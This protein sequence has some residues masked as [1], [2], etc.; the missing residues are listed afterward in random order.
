MCSAGRKIINMKTGTPC[1]QPDELRQLLDGTLSGER[2][3]DCTDHMN[4][5]EC[6]RAKLEEI[7][8]GGSNLSQLVE[9]L[10]KDVPAPTSPYWPAMQSLDL[11]LKETFVPKPVNPL[12]AKPRRDLTLEFLE[13]P[14]DS[15]YLG[16]LAEFDVMR[17]I[18]RGGMG[19]VLEAFDSHLQRHVALKV[20]NPELAEDETA[21]Q[22][23][24]REARAAASITHENVVAVHQVAKSGEYKLPY[25][26]MQL[27]SGES[28]E[29]RLARPPKLPFREIVRIGMQAARGLAAA[30]A[31]GLIHRDIK[32]GNILLET[33]EQRVKLTDFG[34]ARATEDIKLTRTGF[35]TGTPMYMAPEQ[36]HGEEAT[37]QSDLFSLG[38]VIYE[39]CTGKP[40]FTGNSALVVLKQIAEAKPQPISELN[41]Q[42]PE[43]FG[44]TV[45]RL[46]AK[47]P[48]DRMASAA[49]LAE[50]LEF[51]WAIMKTTSEDVPQV[52]QIEEQKK[53]RRNRWL[54]AIIAAS[55]FTVG[56]FAGWLL[57]R[58]QVAI[59][60]VTSMVT[61]QKS[62]KP[63]AVLSGNN[64]A[65]WSESFDPAHDLLA[66]AVEDGSV[67][68]WDVPSQS[69]K[70]TIPAHRGVVWSAR[71]S[72]DGSFL[73][74]AGDDG[75]V[76][77]WNLARSE[78]LRVFQR[79]NAVRGIAFSSDER[80]LYAGDRT[81]G[82]T[83]WS[84]D[85][86]QPVSEASSEGAIYA[87][88]LSPDDQTLV[89][90]GSEKLIRVWNAEN[91]TSRLTLE[92]H[93]GPVY[94][95]SFHPEGQR[96][97]SV[98]WDKTV[99][100]WDTRSGQMIAAWAGHAGDIWGVVYSPDGKKLATAGH[101]GGVR[102]WNAE[103][104]E[105][106]ADY[107]GHELAVHSLA[108]DA[109]GRRLASG[110]RDGTVRI[111]G[112]E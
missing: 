23:F 31:Q 25:L 10:N 80:Q 83:I 58:G 30:H 35:V 41:P 79:G 3:H 60:P 48:S 100:I 109:T 90:A 28:L 102:L 96:L 26:V 76:K 8:T 66:M 16:R 14:H 81:G 68:V 45:D 89:T 19:I 6:C 65:V 69:I 43:W 44:R 37:A 17:V 93:A 72:R 57:P 40:P 13:P 88:A 42:I 22:R 108:F 98:G 18:G 87:V 5:C 11:E 39:M 71:Y 64:G 107:L 94:G 78:P 52:C 97:A 51:E 1:P 82:I 4:S 86:E 53:I 29:Q 111:W 12:S 33:V 27:I 91:L 55:F 85:A 20:L 73:A 106:L 50:L 84:L 49:Q 103:T 34:L 9:H 32:P 56:L 24:C 112:I 75:T 62:I 99:R 38:A 46:L 47:K 59:A 92:G 7:A 36:A 2:Q 101:D 67:R 74:T 104:G 63:L 21:R 110:S 61:A 15:A 77:I 70:T 95:L 54:A 105:L